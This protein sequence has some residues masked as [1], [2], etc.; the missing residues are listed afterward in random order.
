MEEAL[1]VRQDQQEPGRD[2]RGEDAE[3]AGVPD[4]FGAESYEGRSAERQG[5]GGYQTRGCEDSKGG[6]DEAAEVDEGGVQLNGW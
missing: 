6:K 1:E 3:E 5:Q 2:E 4:C